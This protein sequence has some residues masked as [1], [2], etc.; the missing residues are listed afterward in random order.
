VWKIEKWNV[1][2]VYCRLGNKLSRQCWHCSD[3][4]FSFQNWCTET[5]STTF[6]PNTFIG[7]NNS[8]AR[9]FQFACFQLQGCGA[10]VKMIQL[11]LRSSFF[12]NVAPAPKLVIVMWLLLRSS[13]DSRFKKVG[14]PIQDQWKRRVSNINVSPTWWLPVVMNINLMW[15]T[16]S[17]PT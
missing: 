7:G 16:L 12:M 8:R 14:K 10:V 4:Y 9:C 2:S 3:R 15:F 1:V 6:D 17:N 11:R 5:A 13:G